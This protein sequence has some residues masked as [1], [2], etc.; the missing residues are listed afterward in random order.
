M[1]NKF[2]NKRGKYRFVSLHRKWLLALSLLLLVMSTAFSSLNYWYL[3]GQYKIQ[4]AANQAAWRTDFKG[5]IE[6]SVDRLQRL[7]IVIV[8]LGK[9]TEQ[10]NNGGAAIITAELE[11]QFTS[12]SYELDVGRIMIFDRQGNTQWNWS[13]GNNKPVS[14]QPMIDTYKRAQVSEQPETV[15]DC[16][17]QCALITVM[18]LLK[19]GKDAGHIGLSQRIT[20]LVLEFSTATGIDIGILIPTGT[21]DEKMIPRWHLYTAA[22]THAI[23]LKPLISHLSERYA[24]PM[25]IPSDLG[26][27]WNGQF[28]AVNTLPLKDIIKGSN[29]YLVFISNVSGMTAILKQSNRN[30]ILLMVVSLFLAEVLLFLL[31]RR[32]LHRLGHL[33][34]TLP[35]VARGGYHDAYAQLDVQ[36]RLSGTR[37]EIDILY[38]SS[39]NLA[40]QIEESQLALA[41]DRDFI[42]GLLDSAQVMILTQTHTGKIHTA[43]RYMSQLLGRSSENLKGELFVDLMQNDEGKEYY[44]K[45][46]SRLFS[47][48]LHRL[49]HEAS[50]IDAKGELRQ[51]IWNHTYLG[52]TNDD[53]AVLSV[54]LDATDRILAE[55]RS[56]WLAHHDP[57]TGLANRLCFQEDL[58]RSFADSVRSGITSALML[59]DLDYF[60]TVNDTSGHAAGDELL[61]ILANELQSRARASDLVARLGGDEFAV[62]MPNTGQA[63]AE[64]FADS[65]NEL[66]S[67]QVF[68]F[69][70][71]EYRLSAS[72]GIALMP[73]HGK[74]V[75]ELMVNA[76]AAMYAAKNGGRGRYHFFSA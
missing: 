49:G 5:L 18:P 59:I 72:I 50:I 4:L 31:L 54:G 11:K 38:E 36:G 44:E 53:V 51:F 65:I 68:K 21:V 9:L 66:F 8:S 15:L 2:N 55:H 52:Q 13:S 22:L 62:L 47:S 3:N 6:H 30:S 41:S 7:S 32:P 29:G 71:K 46:R 1:T 45:N 61:K 19:G 64:A 76:D 35:M 69:G 67:K 25:D 42:Q 14:V 27:P 12:V 24:S 60:K 34:R 28:Y 56:R 75:E 20:D 37:D 23:T 16:Q 33:A 63:G 17:A 57:L 43:N 10:L 73:L 48:D 39:L 58:V 74:N 40:H 70:N 26:Q